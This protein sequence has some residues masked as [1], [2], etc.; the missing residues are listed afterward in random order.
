MLSVKSCILPSM[1]INKY[2]DTAM[3]NPRFAI[4]ADI[5]SIK[6]LPNYTSKSYSVVSL[7]TTLADTH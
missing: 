5:L 1:R 4:I 3:G 7:S 6:T 2:I